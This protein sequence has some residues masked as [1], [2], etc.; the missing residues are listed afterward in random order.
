M[1]PIRKK[2]ADLLL[3]AS[4]KAMD[5]LD[6][7]NPCTK[8]M[9]AKGSDGSALLRSDIERICTEIGIVEAGRILAITTKLRAASPKAAEKHRK[10]LVDIASKVVARVENKGGPLH[11]PLQCRHFL[12]HLSE[13][14]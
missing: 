1:N 7:E 11:L 3:D 2:L 10:K 4:T 6:A 5:G 12:A 8:A 13:S 14:A 9:K